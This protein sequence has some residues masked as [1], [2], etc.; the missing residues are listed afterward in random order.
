M[1]TDV[2]KFQSSKERAKKEPKAVVTVHRDGRVTATGPGATK[3]KKV[4]ET[5]RPRVEKEVAETEKYELEHPTSGSDVSRRAKPK[6][7]SG[8]GIN[9]ADVGKKILKSAEVLSPGGGSDVRREVEGE[10]KNLAD[11]TAK[12]LNP[13]KKPELAHA[14]TSGELQAAATIL[15]GVGAGEEAGAGEKALAKAASNAS[16]TETAAKTGAK[17]VAKIK[18][19][20]KA[21]A[22]DLRDLP[23]KKVEAVKSAPRRAKATVA[24]APELKTAEGQKAAAKAAGKTAVKH[25]LRTGYLGAAALPP[26]VLP[27][28]VGERARAAAVGSADAVVN[29]PW[30]TFETTARALPAAI[31]GP[32]ALGAAG[33][34]SVLKG[35]PT[36][37]EN[38]AKDQVKGLAQIAEN[39]FSG[40][41]KKAEEAARK[42]GSLS[43][44]TPLPALSKT[45]AVEALRDDAREGTAAVRR[46]VATTDKLPAKDWRNRNV[47]HAPKDV[48][49]RVT[50]KSERHFIRKDIS[51]I[52]QRTRNEH[53]VPA[54]RHAGKILT[55]L[56]KAPKG[57]HI[58]LQTLA[59]YGIRDK[60]GADLIRE[61]GPG[62]KQLLAALDYADLHPD[63]F[64][65]KSFA[66]ALKHS[67]EAIAGHPA[68]AVG[69]GERA[70][71][72]PQGD[73]LGITRPEHMVPF[74][75]RDV[76]GDKSWADAA[77]E[78]EDVLQGEKHQ[79]AEVK[80]D[81]QLKG[82]SRK[83]PLG[84][85]GQ[86]VLK[87]D[88]EK[89]QEMLKEAKK[90][91]KTKVNNGRSQ[92]QWITDA[93]GNKVK[94]RLPV[95]PY[96]DK[97]LKEYADKVEAA[98]TEAGLAK[99]IWTH[100][101]A[102]D[103]EKGSNLP[104]VAPPGRKEYAREGHLAKADN[105]DRSLEGF[106]RG[107]IQKPRYNAASKEFMR[108]VT[109]KYK[110]PFM[111]DGQQVEV[112]HGSADYKR[113]TGPKTKDN[114]DGGQFD[115]KEWTRLPLRQFQNAIDDPFITDSQRNAELQQMVVDAKANQIKGNEP[116]VLVH[117]EVP[118]EVEGQLNAQHSDFVN[119]IN[120]GNRIAGRALLATNPAW[121]V[122]QSV[123]EAVPAIV[124]H[125]SLASP[126]HLPEL[127]RRIYKER[128]EN[129]EQAMAVQAAA[130]ASPVNGRLLNTPID[131]EGVMTPEVWDKGAEGMTHGKTL[132][133]L[134][135]IAKL[136][137]LPELDVK[138][139]NL[140]RE[141]VY[142]AQAD[143][144]FRKWYSGT[145]GLFDG[146]R[147]IS[148]KF[149]GKSSQ[150]LQDWLQ[151]DD[152]QAKAWN[153]KLTEHVDAVQG[154]WGAFT[155]FEK[156]ASPFVIFYPFLRYSLRWALWAYPKE[157]RVRATI[158]NL[159]GQVNANQLEKLVGH[160]LEN[161]SDY[162]YPV[163][164]EGNGEKQ[165]LP[166][167]SRISPAQSSITQAI[168][169]KNPAT[170]AQS[171][172]PVLGAGATAAFGIDSFT[173]EKIHG[174]SSSQAALN[175]LLALPSPLR[176]AGIELGG[177]KSPAAKAFGQYDK[178]KK[179]RSILFPFLPQSGKDFKKEQ[180]LGKAFSEKYGKGHQPGPFD[181]ELFNEIEFGGP[182][183]GIKSKA[184]RKAAIEAVHK[185]EEASGYVKGEEAPFEGEEAG[186]S[187]AQK[188]FLEEWENAW[189]T[190]PNGTA[191][192][193]GGQYGSGEGQY[194][195]GPGQYSKGPGQYSAGAGQ[196]G[197]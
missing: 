56:S 161:P 94:V 125:P 157:H 76:F 89:T 172:N 43:F 32:V 3:A 115:Q 186:F 58:A 50:G 130:G 28:N 196:Y 164:D 152:P 92:K 136:R 65:S 53:A 178:D 195:K 37:L 108:Q 118:K 60:H 96:G 155:R 182:N 83:G 57:S 149:K 111:K 35:S 109:D 4:A 124:T 79:L 175:E 41:P 52:E 19:A 141:L 168:T 8:L 67:E 105:L 104:F 2:S 194:S 100:H 145:I 40:D 61:K 71:L 64:E 160:P 97:E 69:K 140:Y 120:S 153:K 151:S 34:D 192:S 1:P 132:K 117:R 17:I 138:R 159:M 14:P 176:Y 75:K 6:S 12:N 188:E 44:L 15:G 127:L 59:E 101:S 148:R 73:A 80:K 38:T 20:P 90:G 31:T 88:I 54:D 147:E 177:E 22:K 126:I 146:A 74:H 121:L 122:A 134:L 48:T 119:V 170:L 185:A 42:E 49:Q 87:A 110:T 183:G 171:L 106:V 142:R 173:G 82:I 77:K 39:T 29:H 163:F 91:E 21:A 16:N 98:R 51:E 197:G 11:Q 55:D 180:K 78:L 158:L 184:E 81:L 154:N 137:A 112:G 133:S 68:A 113:I 144:K 128:K 143:K 189:E 33:V 30:E 93:E 165:V 129:P 27:G 156:S 45:R 150:E 174:E 103:S 187:P 9:L 7:T 191:K 36:P 24:R 85:H 18:A 123:A 131:E 63:L 66:N 72:Q 139:Q 10:A 102:A 13:T 193:S 62:D 169:T 26:G 135:S 25:P 190:G 5:S 86:S 116:W 47:R 46:K 70:R 181:S 179:A 84:D 95:H 162:A 114:P 99:A 23:K 167:G 166:G 107:T